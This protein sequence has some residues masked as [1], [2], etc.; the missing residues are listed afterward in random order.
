MSGSIDELRRQLLCAPRHAQLDGAD[1]RLRQNVAQI[2]SQQLLLIVGHRYR[3]DAAQRSNSKRRPAES[4]RPAKGRIER[5]GGPRVAARVHGD[6]QSRPGPAGER[7]HAL[8]TRKEQLPAR[9]RTGRYHG[10]TGGCGEIARE[11]QCRKLDVA[12][13]QTPV[14]EMRATPSRARAG[15]SHASRGPNRARSALSTCEFANSFAGRRALGLGRGWSP[16]CA[17]GPRQR[18]SSRSAAEPVGRDSTR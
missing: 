18:T 15:F 8:A 14:S 13:R 12:R 17:R 6:E 5:A 2:R 9:R 11:L 7:H 16:T 4:P 3:P 10:L 1:L